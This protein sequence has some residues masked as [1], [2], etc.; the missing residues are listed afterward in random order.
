MKNFKRLAV[1]LL[2]ITLFC[3]VTKTNTVSV[4]A[5][6]AAEARQ[7]KA[8]LESKKKQAK[9]NIKKYESS[10]NKLFSNIQKLDTKLDKLGRR[11]NKLTTKL[12]NKRADLKQTRIDLKAAKKREKSQYENMKVRIKYMYENGN[13][14]YLTALFHA[15]SF[16]DIMNQKEYVDQVAEYDATMYQRYKD[17]RKEIQK[18]EKKLKKEV[19]EVAEL[20]STVEAE[21]STVQATMKRKTDKMARYQNHVAKSQALISSYNKAIK[22]EERAI[23]R[24]EA[25]AQNN[26]TSSNF[27]YT[28][29][30]L[31]WPCPASS[32][33]T[34]PFGWRIHP[35][36]GG[37]RMHEGVDIAVATGNNI[38]AAESGVVTISQY[39]SS[40]GNY[41][42]I[43]HGGGLS[44]VYMH[45]S[46]LL[47]S[48]GEQVTRGQVIAYS[49]STG[50]STGPHL[51]FAVRLN[52][53]YVNPMPY[54][55]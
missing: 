16:G 54:V 12:N 32:T 46:S 14:A 21:R 31:L 6:T 11:M 26:T 36:N 44:T 55:Q 52:G 7:K 29:G 23:K 41:I 22:A 3:P 48:V 5:R 39:S 53:Q 8:E 47:V 24:A 19:K 40:A 13:E 15:N 10:I 38:L 50:W 49:G 37:G 35:V 9:A 33:I 42:M 51:H 1:L 18:N 4:E 25:A 43:D 20:K 28:G 45:N 2:V 17:T 34:S 30:K 27:T